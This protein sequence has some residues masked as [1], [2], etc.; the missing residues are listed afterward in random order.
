M[1]VV[2]MLILVSAEG[3]YPADAPVSGSY[4]MQK[5]EIGDDFLSFLVA[6][7]ERDAEV[8]LDREGLHR[9]FPKLATG[10]FGMLREVDRKTAGDHVQLFFAFVDD[11]HVPVP[12]GILWYH[13]IWIDTS[14]SV[15]LRESRIASR[16]LTKAG[17]QSTLLAPQYE[18]RL[19]GGHASVRID[20]WL[21]VV[22]VGLL[23]DFSFQ[24]VSLFNESG[25][26]YG[27]LA[28]RGPGNR[29]VSWLFNLTT[30]RVVLPMPA[31]YYTLA[32]EL[33]SSTQ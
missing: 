21:T 24:A 27:L 29:P 33:V 8:A 30:M 4:R 23:T 2:I 11:L 16:T 12:F 6:V 1:L 19:E 32:A 5:G 17:G 15:S 18:Y 3:A 9:E 13:P 7:I 22:T 31:E 20:H 26:W 14:G 28:G 10:L 25:S